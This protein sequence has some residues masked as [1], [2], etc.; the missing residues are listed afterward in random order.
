MKIMS[1]KYQQIVNKTKKKARKRVKLPQKIQDYMTNLTMD[2]KDAQINLE[3]IEKVKMNIWQSFDSL[4]QVIRIMREKGLLGKLEDWDDVICGD[5]KYK[6]KMMQD[7][8]EL[9]LDGVIKGEEKDME[10][11]FNYDD[12]EDFIDKVKEKTQKKVKRND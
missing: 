5:C 1:K 3:K 11:Y 6:K 7:V 8:I 12:W 10:I 2:M 4:K 9:E